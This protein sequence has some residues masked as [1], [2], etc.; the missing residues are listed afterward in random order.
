MTKRLGDGRQHAARGNGVARRALACAALWAVTGGCA[1]TATTTAA[2]RPALAPPDPRGEPLALFPPGAVSW[3]RFDL[4]TARRSPH[5]DRALETAQ[6]AGVQVGEVQRALGFDALRTSEMVAYALYMPPGSGQVRGGWPVVMARGGFTRDAVLAA[7]RQGGEAVEEG[8]ESGVAYTAVG[9]R[10]LMFP[11]EGVVLVLPRSL[12]RR[13]AERLAGAERRSVLDDDRFSA[14][15]ER[16]GGMDGTLRVAVDL[17]AIRA[18]AQADLRGAPPAA[19]HLDALV[20]KADLPA[21]VTVQAAGLASDEAAAAAT[22]RGVRAMVAEVR[23][24]IV[25]LLG[26]GRL[27]REGIVASSEGR[28]VSLTVRANEGEARRAMRIVTMLRED[29]AA[30]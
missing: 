19:G 27:M 22:V 30:E 29:A 6:S 16:V 14:L 25:T 5:F 24:A 26:L 20:A 17:A 11:A 8:R 1:T 28:H 12:L 4:A 9:Q 18:R 7:A 15:W 3:G 13:E 10:V 2:A 21:D 23:G